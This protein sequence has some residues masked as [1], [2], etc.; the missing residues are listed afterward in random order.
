MQASAFIKGGD[1]QAIP[2]VV[3]LFGGDGF[4]KQSALR[5]IV[6][7]VLGDEENLGLTRLAGDKADLK[8]VVDTLLTTSMYSPR[9]VVVVEDAD[10][11]VSS[12]RE[13]LERYAE[14]PA[15]KS[16]LVL[17]VRTWPA[18]TRLAKKVAATGLPVDCA[19]LKPA[20]LP[21]WLIEHSRNRHGKQL[22]RDAAQR[23]VELAGADLGLLDQELAKL[24][25]YVGDAARIDAQAV[26][27]LVGGW[28]AETTWKML[29]AVRDGRF[30][31]ALAMLDKLL[32]S[33]EHP[34]KLLGGVNFTFRPIAKA[35]ELSRRGMPLADALAQAGAKPFTIQPTIAYLR[36]LTRP[37]AERLYGWL[38]QADL[39][40]K[41][42]SPAPE[43]VVIESL[44]VQLSGKK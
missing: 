13:G 31:V 44:L 20:E 1:K 23:L 18:T 32:V 2:P 38:L 27:R 14:R 40:L 4:L 25:A 41:G 3:A 19:P 28:K 8:T 36:R 30:D 33:G 24:A 29:D 7:R 39:D 34:L 22:D 35:V 10:G 12:F 15:K 42:A 11:F 17:D 26:E 21:G 9:Q 6:G 16:V 43:R 37:T 5:L